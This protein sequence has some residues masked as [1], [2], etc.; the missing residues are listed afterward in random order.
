MTPFLLSLIV[1]IRDHRGVT[2]HPVGMTA[3][4]Q[5]VNR[6]SHKATTLLE[7]CDYGSLEKWLELLVAGDD[8]TFNKL[9][10]QLETA[11]FDKK[12]EIL[13]SIKRL[14]KRIV[15]RFSL[16][17]E[18]VLSELS[19]TVTSS[20]NLVAMM[21]RNI[22]NESLQTA[23]LI[24]EADSCHPG[25][26][27]EIRLVDHSE[28]EEPI[29]RMTAERQLNEIC[30]VLKVDPGSIELIIDL[31]EAASPCPSGPCAKDLNPSFGDIE[32]TFL[33]V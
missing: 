25:G 22:C 8:K 12:G 30:K 2:P 6:L 17:L 19:E 15:L 18:T 11:E 14:S 3:L 7:A 26:C 28:E 31:G 23:V 10:C 9:I 27:L 1:I 32:Q 29:I 5:L 33:S 20:L 4:C 13:P 21:T 16:P 24:E